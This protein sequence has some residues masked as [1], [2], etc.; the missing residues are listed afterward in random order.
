M[1]GR[2]ELKWNGIVFIV[3]DNVKDFVNRIIE[4]ILVILDFLI[5]K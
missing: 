1:I 5:C 3:N 2:V 4:F